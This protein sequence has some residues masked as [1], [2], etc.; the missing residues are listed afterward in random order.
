MLHLQ[1]QKVAEQLAWRVGRHPLALAC[2]GAR[3]HQI[4][5]LRQ[6]E[7]AEREC[8]AILAMPD[9]RPLGA[10]RTVTAAI[11]LSVDA[12]GKEERHML[13]FLASFRMPVPRMVVWKAWQRRSTVSAYALLDQLVSRHHAATQIVTYFWGELELLH[14]HD[15]RHQYLRSMAPVRSLPAMLQPIL[16]MGMLAGTAAVLRCSGRSVAAAS[17]LVVYGTWLMYKADSRRQ[18]LQHLL[19]HLFGKERMQTASPDALL[20]LAAMVPLLGEEAL[21]GIAKQVGPS[22]SNPGISVQ[23]S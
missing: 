13:F 16:Q 10:A 6:W 15:L 22:L 2:F 20:M 5:S 19:Q 17:S 3:L 7:E 14:L 9:L 8:K 21:C 1:V 4:S 23:K 18:P 12:L 11:Q